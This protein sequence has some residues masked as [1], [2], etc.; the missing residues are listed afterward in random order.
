M[1]HIARI[2]H[3]T[4][5]HCNWYTFFFGWLSINI[6]IYTFSMIFPSTNHPLK[7]LVGSFSKSHGEV[8]AREGRTLFWAAVKGGF[9]PF[10]DEDFDGELGW[11]WMDMDGS[12]WCIQPKTWGFRRNDVIAMDNDRTNHKTVGENQTAIMWSWN[13][14]SMMVA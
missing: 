3:S 1:I 12:W 5:I 2:L 9:G 10:K 7:H 8:A 4:I 6:Y 14:E 11:N 13:S